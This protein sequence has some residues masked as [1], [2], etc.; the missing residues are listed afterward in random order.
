MGIQF[1]YTNPWK[2][3]ITRSRPQCRNHSTENLEDHAGAVYT[4][5]W[6]YDESSVAQVH[7]ERDVPDPGK[8]ESALSALE[9]LGNWRAHVRELVV[10]QVCSGHSFLSP[11]A[12]RIAMSIAPV[13][14]RTHSWDMF[15]LGDKVSHRLFRW[16][17]P[18]SQV[19][20]TTDNRPLSGSEEEK[21]ISGSLPRWTWSRQNKQCQ[22]SSLLGEAS[23]RP[24]IS[25]FNSQWEPNP[26]H[27][28]RHAD[29]GWVTVLETRSYVRT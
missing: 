1:Q 8:H 5:P 21:A 17:F 26:P 27:Q 15:T 4:W 19:R 22:G 16:F 7:N 25:D 23:S 14:G 28:H 3:H 13:T 9:D 20:P 2:T 11:S 18:R 12:D 6:I 24:L 29:W 10:S